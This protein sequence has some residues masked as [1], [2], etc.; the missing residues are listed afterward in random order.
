MVINLCTDVV[1]V[2]VS[3]YVTCKLYTHI[4]NDIGDNYTINNWFYRLEIKQLGL[5]LLDGAHK[6]NR[7]YKA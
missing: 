3:K 1:A 2:Y 5:F 4:S 7:L 6:I